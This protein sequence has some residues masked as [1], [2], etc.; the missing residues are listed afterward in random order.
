M[1]RTQRLCEERVRLL[2]ALDLLPQTFCHHDAFRRNLM[3]RSRNSGE[4]E[5]VAIDWAMVGTGCVGA[6]VATFVGSTLVFYEI[7]AEEILEYETL[8][9]TNYV[10]GLRD[11]GWQGSDKIVRFAYA[12]NISLINALGLAGVMLTLFADPEEVRF[13]ERFYGRPFEELMSQRAIMQRYFLDLG[14]EALALMAEL[15]TVG[16]S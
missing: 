15:P 13:H 9:L 7:A 8:A 11:A 3:I 6:E 4:L 1:A 10:K 2:A 5:T 14:E 16:Q 12:A